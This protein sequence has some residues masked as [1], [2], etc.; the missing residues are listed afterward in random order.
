M[1]HICLC[2]HMWILIWMRHV[3]V[4]G[5]GQVSSSVALHFIVWDRVSS[6]NLELTDW[7]ASLWDPFVSGLD[8]LC[9]AQLFNE[10][11]ISKL[12]FSFSH[13]CFPTEPSPKPHPL[14]NDDLLVYMYTR[15]TETCVPLCTLYMWS[16][17]SCWSWFCPSC[18]SWDQTHI[19]HHTG[20]Q[21][22]NFLSL[23]FFFFFIESRLQ[24]QVEC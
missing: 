7:P 13:S 2:A 1:W 18:R 4:R 3:E 8:I 20:G 17:T 21:R 14:K 6:L 15:E 23:F 11:G 19:C 22:L 12:R 5:W 24:K 10:C 16:R 9:Q